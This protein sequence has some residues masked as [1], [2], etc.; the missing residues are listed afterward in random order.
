MVHWLLEN[1]SDEYE[2]IF[3]FANTSKEREETLIFAD[4]VDKK[5]NINLVLV[6]DR[7]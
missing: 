7:V 2:M 5:Y 4:K 3:V 1:K 6:G